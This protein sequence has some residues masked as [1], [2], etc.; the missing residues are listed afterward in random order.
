[1]E[2][3]KKTVNKALLKEKRRIKRTKRRL[4]KI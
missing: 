4:K 3:E 2:D 1:M